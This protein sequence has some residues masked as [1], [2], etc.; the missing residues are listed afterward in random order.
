MVPPPAAVASEDAAVLPVASKP[1]AED[2]K[3]DDKASTVGT[4]GAKRAADA[5]GLPKKKARKA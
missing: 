1:I 2:R 4:N 5:T 3:A